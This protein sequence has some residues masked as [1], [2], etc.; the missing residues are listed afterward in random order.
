MRDPRN[1]QCF[2][3]TSVG[4]PALTLPFATLC[5]LGWVEPPASLPLFAIKK[6]KK[7][8]H[9]FQGSSQAE[10]SCI[11]HLAQSSSSQ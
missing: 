10:M 9:L 6:K 8:N 3:Q 5:K 11:R 4:I 2:T 1:T 7:R